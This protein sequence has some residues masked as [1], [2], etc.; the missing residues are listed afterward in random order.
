MQRSTFLALGLA[1]SISAMAQTVPVAAAGP[2]DTV[3]A[4]DGGSLAL[5]GASRAEPEVLE[6]KW[7]D[8]TT[9]RQVKPVVP[10]FAKLARP[11]RCKIRFTVDEAGL[12]VEIDVAECPGV[13]RENATKAA[14]KW[15]FEPYIQDGIARKTHFAAILVIR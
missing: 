10:P 11:I 12:P 6:L 4:A 14:R 5:D 8:V 9:R 7:H 13:L 15:R 2:A 1:G 3:A